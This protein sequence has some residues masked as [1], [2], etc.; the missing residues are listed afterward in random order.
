MHGIRQ[1]LISMDGAYRAMTSLRNP[2]NIKIQF[3]I[4]SSF[5]LKNRNS[6]TWVLLALPVCPTSTAAPGEVVGQL[7]YLLG[8]HGLFTATPNRTGM[9]RT[10]LQH[11]R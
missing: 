6:R 1:S 2:L 10:P 9:I 8:N 11:N 7:L 4:R 5:L 3:E